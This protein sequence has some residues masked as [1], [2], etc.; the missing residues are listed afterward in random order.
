MDEIDRDS[1]FEEKIL[2]ANIAAAARIKPEAEATG[3]CLNC[4]VRVRKG[5]RWCCPDCRDDWEAMNKN[6]GV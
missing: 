5:M 6:R 3:R 2:A 4:T 1:E